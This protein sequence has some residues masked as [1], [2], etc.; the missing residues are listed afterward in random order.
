MQF[1]KAFYRRSC[2]G[3]IGGGRV[4]ELC[5]RPLLNIAWPQ[6]AGILQVSHDTLGYYHNH[7]NQ[8]LLGMRIFNFGNFE[9]LICMKLYNLLNLSK[10]QKCKKNN[11]K[12]LKKTKQALFLR[13][14]YCH[15]SKFV[16]GIPQ[17][18]L[19]ILTSQTALS[20]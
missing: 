2:Q 11:V 5:V 6:L 17:Y 19:Q 12:A 16:Y 3:E 20:K 9:C 7:D 18:R 14:I 4:T 13:R 8:L 15:V 1:V 10:I